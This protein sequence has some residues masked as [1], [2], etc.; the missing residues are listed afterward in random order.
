MG[1]AMSRRL[2]L[3]LSTTALVVVAACGDDAGT[4]RPA[5]DGGTGALP[6][7]PAA[8]DGGGASPGPDVPTPAVTDPGP[9]SGTLALETVATGLDG[10]LDLAWR[11]GDPDAL[12]VV[13]QPGR[14][15]VIR[16][17]QLI[18]EPV[19]DISE[20]VTIGGESG[21]LGLA[22]HPDPADDRVFV[23]YTGP[24]A[25]QIVSSFRLD[26]TNPDR[27]LP[28]SEQVLLSMDDQFSN[29]NG[30]SLVFGPDG[31]LYI[32]TGDGG[33]AGD[34]LGSGRSLGTLLA[35]VLRI[36]IDRTGD[37]TPYGIPDDNPFVDVA[38]ARP[39]IWHTGL[40]NPWRIRF[41]RETGDMWIG[42]VGQG[43][44]EEIDHAPAGVGGFDFG[45]NRMEG[46][47]CFS[48]DCDSPDFTPPVA[49]YG[50]DEGCSVTGGTVYRGAAEPDLVGR[51]VFADYCS[52]RVW[53]IDAAAAAAGGLQ[54]P[55]PALDSGRSISAIAEDAAGELY[56]TDLAA[57]DV[58]RI[59]VASD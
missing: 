35:K 26:A 22:F 9:W 11:T 14:I 55:V 52:G 18:A 20:A 56:A 4:S 45:W 27:I 40:R 23:Y 43:D 16:D 6:S 30:G 21:L 54:E 50:H 48:G 32:G 7:S 12:Y 46:T 1:T 36:D 44:W 37:G 41:D 28:D 19:L 17:G 53:T 51:Y 57:G 31:Y 5:T 59:G 25:R 2:I 10:P 47:H 8:T 58:V 3:A 38:G 34:P 15:R 39:E 13:E 42:D 24:E 49:E 33:G 29:H